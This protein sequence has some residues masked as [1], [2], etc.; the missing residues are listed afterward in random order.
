MTGSKERHL[1]RC[2]R[3]GSDGKQGKRRLLFGAIF[4]EL[5]LIFAL[6]PL[7]LAQ[8]ESCRNRTLAVNVYDQKGE[9]VKNLNAGNSRGK[10]R[11]RP[12]R[13]T[14]AT[15]DARPCRVVILVDVSGSVLGASWV[16][17]EAATFIRNLLSASPTSVSFAFMAFASRIEDQV[18][19]NQGRDK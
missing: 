6:S 4:V 1:H 16:T 19:F 13:I 9:P 7:T 3:E 15:N 8:S 14:S 12:I 2:A 5:S 11:G 17:D 10:L 18:S